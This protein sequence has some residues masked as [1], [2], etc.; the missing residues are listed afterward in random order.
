[1]LIVRRAAKSVRHDDDP[2]PPID[3]AEDRCENAYVSFATRYDQRVHT[4]FPEQTVEVPFGPGRI[5]ALIE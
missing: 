4:G 5:D 1:M 3:C 2:K